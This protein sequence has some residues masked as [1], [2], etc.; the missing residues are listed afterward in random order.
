MSDLYVQIMFAISNLPSV[1]F[2][3]KISMKHNITYATRISLRISR[4]PDNFLETRQ[5]QDYRNKDLDNGE[6]T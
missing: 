3:F 4:F 2:F 1:F 6:D 5:D